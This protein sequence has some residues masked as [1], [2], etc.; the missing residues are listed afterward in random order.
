MTG[1]RPPKRNADGR[2]TVRIGPANAA[3]LHG[4]ADLRNWDDEELLRGQRRAKTGSFVGRPPT[5]VPMAVHDELNRRRFSRAAEALNESLEEAVRVLREIVSD[6]RASHA[7]RLKAAGMILDRVLGRAPERVQ[8]SVIDE[9]A[10]WMEA[11][12]A[13]IVATD[14]AIDVASEEV[15][16]DD[17]PLLDDELPA[18]PAAPPVHLGDIADRPPPEQRRTPRQNP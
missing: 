12:V 2:A 4:E 16:L 13:G 8:L 10:P 6:G 1:Y 11:L 17:D 18:L 9:K 3:I 7:D 14:G 15:L 5:V